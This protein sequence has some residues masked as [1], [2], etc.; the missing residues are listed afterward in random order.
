[1]AVLNAAALL[2]TTGQSQLQHHVLAN[3]LMAIVHL[4]LAFLRPPLY[5]RWRLAVVT[6]LR[7]SRMLA[8]SMLTQHYSTAAARS[9]L[10]GDGV[11]DAA[12]C[13]VSASS[14]G[15]GSL[16]GLLLLSPASGLMLTALALP[17]PLRLHL[18]V[19]A[20]TTLAAL[21]L[22][23]VTCSNGG[24][25]A[26]LNTPAVLGDGAGGC[27]LMTQLGMTGAKLLR[28]LPLLPRRTTLVLSDVQCCQHV[29][30]LAVVCGGLVLPSL[31]LLAMEASTR[32]AFL[33]LMVTSSGV[34]AAA[35]QAY[36]LGE[37]SSSQQSGRNSGT[38]SG[39]RLQAR[40]P[41]A[42]QTG[43]ALLPAALAP[44]RMQVG[45]RPVQTGDQLPCTEIRAWVFRPMGWG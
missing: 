4:L 32:S 3:L 17:L 10:G 9:L 21:Q 2:R 44:L 15:S 24:I 5:S 14:S 40:Q 42:G 12:T 37:G 31:V 43:A 11:D 23:A 34:A 38:T 1:V 7:V 25:Q 26:L 39:S 36:G 30:S 35:H 20:L 27:T 22:V 16:L 8:V 28:P 33:R 13:A 45:P 41:A 29:I 18:P 6:V 19:Q